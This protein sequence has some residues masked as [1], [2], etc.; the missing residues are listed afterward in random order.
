M[1]FNAMALDCC[2]TLEDGWH[3]RGPEIVDMVK[4]AFQGSARQIN[5]LRPKA[6]AF[7]PAESCLSDAFEHTDRVGIRFCIRRCIP[8]SAL[9]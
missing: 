5:E 1:P 7:L 8:H 9:L 4:L 3:M 6:D 2:I